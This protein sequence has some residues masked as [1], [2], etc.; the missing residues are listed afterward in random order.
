VER[1]RLWWTSYHFQGSP[2][3][4]LSQKLK[5]LNID[6]KRWNEHEFGNVE[7]RKNMLIEK[8]HRDFLWGALGEEF[9]YHPVSWSTV[10][11]PIS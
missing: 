3:F 2:S 6:L 9:K 7:V 4:I 1:V 8:L 11:S 5:A 10:C